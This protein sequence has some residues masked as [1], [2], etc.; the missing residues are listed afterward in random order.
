MKRAI[1]AIVSLIVL[2]GFAAACNGESRMTVAEYARWCGDNQ[3]N[4]RFNDGDLLGATWG[5]LEDAMQ[6][7]LDEYDRV[8]GQ[9]PDEASLETFHRVQ[10]GVVRTVLVFARQQD[11]DEVF[12]LFELL[13]PVLSVAGSVEAAEAA[14]TPS[15]RVALISTGCIDEQTATLEVEQQQQNNQPTVAKVDQQ[16]DAQPAAAKV[17]QTHTYTH[18]FMLNRGSWSCYFTIGDKGSIDARRVRR[19]WIWSMFISGLEDVQITQVPPD[20]TFDGGELII[21]SGELDSGY[22]LSFS[23]ARPTELKVELEILRDNGEVFDVSN[24]EDFTGRTSPRF[25]WTLP[26]GSACER[27]RIP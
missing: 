10:R 1:V 15:T 6:V 20:K 9:I 26:L 25:R 5:E 8:D 19:D 12:T 17:E 21:L 11:N 7:L 23:L 22:W 16:Q 3:T 14:L 24:I 27:G 4:N 2:A 18:A 13:A